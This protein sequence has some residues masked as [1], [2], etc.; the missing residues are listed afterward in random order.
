MSFLLDT[1]VI[2]EYRKGADCDPGVAEWFAKVPD[3]KL[4]LSV[5]VMG[6]LRKGAEAKARRDPVQAEALRRWIALVERG[7]GDRILPFGREEAD[8][9][10]RMN[11]LRPRSTVDSMLAATA[12]VHGMTLVTRNVAD[13]DG[14]GVDV[15]NPFKR[16]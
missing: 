13:V 6:E 8:I 3:G 14:L 15:L 7:Y 4:Y 2:S 10:G 16:P 1:N 11:A 9:W 12:K 5:L